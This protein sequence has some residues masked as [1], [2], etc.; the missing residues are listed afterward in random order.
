MASFPAT[1]ASFVTPN[2]TTPRLG[3]GALHAQEEGEIVAIE[4]ALGANLSNVRLIPVS[5][6]TWVAG[7]VSAGTAYIVTPIAGTISGY[8][9]QGTTAPAVPGLVTVTLG[10]A[11][12]ILLNAAVASA[13]SVGLV[14]AMTNTSGTTLASAGQSLQINLGAS[15]T[16]YQQ[17][18]SLYVT[19]TS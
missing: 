18:V 6:G 10:S 5:L 19:R 14:T 1:I 12:A 4:T 11:G 17:S 3:H 8:F 16:A 9:C 15:G 2:G 7:S 13:G